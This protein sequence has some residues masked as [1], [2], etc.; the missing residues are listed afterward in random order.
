MEIPILQ[1]IAIIFGISIIVLFVCDKIHLPS[2][3]GFLLTGTLIGPHGFNLIISIHEVEIFAEFGVVLLLFT[4]G[5][6]L[7][8]KELLRNKKTVLLGGSLQVL[9]TIL[10]TFLIA[11]QSGYSPGEA[12]FVGFLIA[13]SSTAIVLELFRAKDAIHS[14]QG[15]IILAILIFQDIIMVVMMLVTP[16]LKGTQADLTTSLLLLLVKTIIIIGLVIVC[17]RYIVPNLLYQIAKRRNQELFLLSIVAICCLVAWGSSSM[18]LSLGLGAFLAGL[19]ISESEYSLRALGSVLPF[20]SVFIS[21]FFISIGILFDSAFLIQN[22]LQIFELTFGV[23]LIKVVVLFL[24]SGIL[25]LQLRTAII[26]SLSLGQIGEFSFLLSR[27]GLEFELLNSNSYQLFLSVAVLSMALTPL[28]VFIAPRFADMIMRW[29]IPHRFK[30]G[31]A[32]PPQ[33]TGMPNDKDLN[34]HLVIIGLGIN[35]QLLVQTAKEAAIPFILVE[36]NAETVK[37]ERK[38]G[39]PVLYGDATQDTLLKH[40]HVQDAFVIV[41][42]ISDPLA[43]RRIVQAA[44]KLNPKA[45]IIARTRFVLEVER[46]IKLGASEVV[47]VEFEAALKIQR[48]VLTHYLIPPNEIEHF[49]EKATEGGYRR[50]I[51]TTMG[52][53]FNQEKINKL[54]DDGH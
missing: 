18:G 36:M 16:L 37:Q 27:M 48:E 13:L 11:W 15:Q 22:F 9:L 33:A 26:I 45:H 51:S 49:L 29:P 25:Q 21:F 12:L 6:E 52:E 41:I 17:T 31:L 28:L 42:A 5:L 50:Y 1:D 24:V 44:R 20:H 40:A 47:P 3:I 39:H 19:V 4:I 10:I 8:F 7:S 43:T 23:I 14:P 34:D 2:I 53:H 46:L 35:G 38:K 54:L 30:S 32:T